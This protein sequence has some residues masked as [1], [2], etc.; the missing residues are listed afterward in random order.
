[1][2]RRLAKATGGV[3]DMRVVD[4]KAPFGRVCQPVDV[5]RVVLW[6][7]SDGAGYVT[8]QRVECDGGIPNPSVLR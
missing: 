4:A 1:M 3:T 8:G 2:G 6:L 5:A 7:A